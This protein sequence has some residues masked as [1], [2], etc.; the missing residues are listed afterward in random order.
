MLQALVGIIAEQA[1]VVSASLDQL[2]DDQFIETC[3]L[4]VVPY[5]GDLIGFTPLRPLGP[6]QP[7][8]T[9][10]EVADT[11]GYRSARAPLAM[12]EQL[13]SDVTGWPGMAVEYFTR[14]STTQYVRNHLRLDNAIVDVH[15]PIT[16]VDVGG[17]FDLPPRSADVRRI[18]SGR[19]RYNIPNIGLFVWRLAPYGNHGHPVAPWAEPVHLRPL[20]RRCAPGES[21]GKSAG[22][23]PGT[24]SISFSLV[25]R[26][27]CRS[28]SSAIP[29]SPRPSPTRRRR[30]SV[31][32]SG[33]MVGTRGDQL[34]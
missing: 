27:H 9:R 22:E 25:D 1:Q 12:L 3:A 33:A 10:A 34:V 29:S 30:R 8:A 32:V 11:I 28:S 4:W 5:I 13:C 6:G 21:A 2:Y 31:T 17:A 16:A 14:L 15:S 7:S 19:G 26:P 18:D 24:S 23:P 20:R